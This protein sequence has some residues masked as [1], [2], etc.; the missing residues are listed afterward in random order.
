MIHGDVAFIICVTAWRNDWGNRLTGF[1]ATRQTK[2]T[3]SGLRKNMFALSCSKSFEYTDRFSPP[4]ENADRERTERAQQGAAKCFGMMVA[5]DGVEPPTPAFSAKLTCSFN[6]LKGLGGLR[7]YLTGC[8][9][10]IDL[11]WSS[12]VCFGEFLRDAHRQQQ[13]RNRRC[14]R[15]SY[16]VTAVK[17]LHPVV[18]NRNQRHGSQSLELKGTVWKSYRT[19]IEP[20]RTL[21]HCFNGLP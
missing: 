8:K 17:A 6:D 2:R 21:A 19:L 11:G 4:S 1:S 16:C 3:E 14:G 9:R 10:D 13:L 18:T 20:Y 12:R 7:K 5:R 15:C